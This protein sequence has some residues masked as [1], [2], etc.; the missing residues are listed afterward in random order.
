MQKPVFIVFFLLFFTIISTSL[1]VVQPS[2]PGAIAPYLNGIFPK[3]SPNTAWELED[4]MPNITLNAPLRIAPFPNSEDHLVL[5]K[6]GEIWRITLEDQVKELVLDIKDRCFKKG[7]GGSVGMALHPNFGKENAPKDQYVLVFYRTKP[8]PDDWDERG[9][10]RL[11]KFYWDKNNRIFD[12][13]TEEILI[14]QYDRFTWHNGGGMFFGDDGFFYMTLGDEGAEEYQVA[15]TQRLDGGLFSGLIRID[16][17]R[18]SSKSHPIRRQPLFNET[19]PAGWGATFSQGYFIPNDNPWQSPDSSHLEEFYAIGLRSPHGTFYDEETGQIWVTDV[20]SSIR[21]EVNIIEKGDNLQWPYMEGSVPSDVH[22]KPN[23]LIGNEKTA[24]FEYSREEIGS[25]IVGGSIYR[26]TKFPELNGKFL[27]ADWNN[28]KLLALTNT[29]NSGATDFEF[30]LES[31]DGQPVD[32]PESPAMTGVF[33]IEDGRILICVMGEN[34]F[35][36][37]KIFS[38]KKKPT[39]EEPPALLSE[40]GVFKDLRTLTPIEGLIPYKV[41]SPLWSD[42]AVKKRWM[43]IPND[44]IF[45]TADEKIKFNGNEEWVF[46]SGTVFVKHFE[47]PSTTDPDGPTI[48]LETRFFVIDEAGNGYGLT[49]KWNEEGNEAF[50]QGGGTSKEFD[51]YENGEIEFVQKWDYPSRD[52]C[53]SCHNGNAKFVLGVKTHQLNGKLFYPSLNAEKNQLEFLS[54]L[55]IFDKKIGNPNNYLKAY[56]IDDENAALELRV[57]SY[58]DANCSSCHRSGGVNDVT[59]N[60]SITTPLI[61]QPLINV[62]TNSQNSNPHFDIVEPGFHQSSELWIRDASTEENKMPPIARNLVD[63]EYVDALAEWIDG[64]PEDTGLIS[65]MFLFPNPTD[66]WLNLKI[67]DDW[68]PPFKVIVRASLG[69]TFYHQDYDEHAILLNLNNLLNGTYILDISSGEERLL[70]KIVLNR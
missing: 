19:P 29:G 43:A 37:G 41:N 1:I 61:L 3:S 49:Y 22:K 45:D 68:T 30:L 17:D 24:F 42:R 16:V 64:L 67:S 38:L 6:W 21:E 69:R 58:L 44:G 10:N 57:R 14:Q 8:N 51:I 50:L 20:G 40:L 35:K 56:A 46:P 52:Q 4:P 62:P 28:D 13:N 63:E 27:V 26:G 18:D 47:L 60:F 70:R 66:G 55:G 11:S 65:E 12:S 48:R 39:V 7:D 9:F 23:Q 54:D 33:P 59:L 34:A 36:P 5:C 25:C 15:S 2:P 53:L 32:L 31:L